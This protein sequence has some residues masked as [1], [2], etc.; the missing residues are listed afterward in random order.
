MSLSLSIPHLT[1]GAPR[2]REGCEED[3][4][5]TT[6]KPATIELE[7][8]SAR[9][10]VDITARVDAL[11]GGARDG[12]CHLFLKHTTAGLMILT[13]EAGVPEDI[14]DI[15]QTLVPRGRTGTTRRRT[16]PRIS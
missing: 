13:G 14:M 16:W 3:R 15:L 5:M 9:E 10:I 12:S 2:P 8:L 1:G 11:L 7:T 4:H 6:T